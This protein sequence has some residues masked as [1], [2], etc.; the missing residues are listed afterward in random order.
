MTS[1]IGLACRVVL[2]FPD[3]HVPRGTAVKFQHRIALALSV[4]LLFC[5]AAAFA[6][7]TD[8]QQDAPQS[9]SQIL[10]D[11]KE[12]RSQLDNPTGEYSRFSEADIAKMKRAQD[13][14]FVMLS[15]VDSLDQLNLDQKTS[16]SNSLDV[17]KAT[18]LADEGNRLIC[19][20]ERKIGTNI[21]TKRCET[22]A[23][24]NAQAKAAQEQMREMA[25]TF[26]TKSGG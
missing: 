10:H 26:Q 24:R 18:L 6:D 12:L 7:S 25:P 17:I 16:L 15:G 22:V 23:E 8:P 21:V 13:S 1:V 14:V 11:Q 9:V 2:S 5:S 19:H 4:S 20:R 3:L